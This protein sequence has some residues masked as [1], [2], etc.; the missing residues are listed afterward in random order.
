MEWEIDKIICAASAL[1]WMLYW[2]VVIKRELSLKAKLSIYFPT[3]TFGYE[4]W[5][6]TTR[7][8]NE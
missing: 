1:M 6:V 5:V 2:Y 3:L 8:L 4:L 7:N